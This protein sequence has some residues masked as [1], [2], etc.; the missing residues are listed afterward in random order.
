[1]KLTTNTFRPHSARMFLGGVVLAAASA[2]VVAAHAAP[3]E[4]MHGG[5]G[6]GMG[7]GMMG[8]GHHVEHMLGGVNATP[9][10]RTQIHQIMQSAM[11]DMKT[12]REAGRALREQSRTLL[13]QPNIDARAVE[14]NRVQ[15]MALHEQGSKRM[16]QAMVD[17]AKVLTPEQRKQLGDRMAQRG[18][19]MERHQA[20]RRSL[21]K[22]TP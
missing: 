13:A 21:D 1:M 2:F 17:A 20:E 10:Q 4:G 19:M 9:E 11:A 5:M 8:G 14:A 3:H 6:M 16:S 15:L 12:Q 18:A 7:M 22:K